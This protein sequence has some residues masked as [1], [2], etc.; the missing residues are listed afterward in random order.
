MPW[1]QAILVCLGT[2]AVVSNPGLLKHP[3]LA[4][5]VMSKPD[6]LRSAGL[7]TLV[8]SYPGLRKY[9]GLCTLVTTNPHPTVVPWL[10]CAGGGLP[11]YPWH[12][13]HVCVPRHVII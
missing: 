7:G 5:V 2:V 4:T 10:M 8:M 11:R 9:L 6:L 1:R 3:G 12:I 13:T